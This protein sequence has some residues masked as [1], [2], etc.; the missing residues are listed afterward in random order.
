MFFYKIHETKFGTLIA[1]CDKELSGKTLKGKNIEVFVNPRFYGEEE[2]GEEILNL[3]KQSN[4]GN[5]IGKK[6][7]NLLLKHKIISKKSVI[8]IEG[9]PHAQFA[10]L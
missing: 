1:V 10:I 4:D 3:V 5:V 2:S 6:I 8:K 9:I 7:V